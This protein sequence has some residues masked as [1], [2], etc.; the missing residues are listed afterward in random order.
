MPRATWF[1][2]KCGAPWTTYEEAT[3]CEYE[4]TSVKTVLAEEWDP[5][6]CYLHEPTRIRIRTTDGKEVWYDKSINQ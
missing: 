4:H 2:N 5:N 1:C 6:E 3:R